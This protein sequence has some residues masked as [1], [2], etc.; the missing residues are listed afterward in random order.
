M[1][2]EASF[3][4]RLQEG[5]AAY[6]A[7]DYATALPIFE[8]LGEMNAPNV[9]FACGQMYYNGQGTDVDKARA[10]WWMERAAEVGGDPEIM[11][12][13]GQMYDDGDGVPVDKARALQWYERSARDG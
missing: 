9:M 13:C 6:Q 7:G 2:T 10:L 11:F 1:S 5:V 4:Q 3:D 8:E 12:F